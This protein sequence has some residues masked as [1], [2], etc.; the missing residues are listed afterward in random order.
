[1]GLFKSAPR[2]DAP[3]DLLKYFYTISALAAD[4]F[5]NWHRTALHTKD[6]SN[7]D[8]YLH[9]LRESSTFWLEASDNGMSNR[10]IM[11]IRMESGPRGN[12]STRESAMEMM[13]CILSPRGFGFA[14][15]VF[16]V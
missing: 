3:G 4:N 7:V 10:M 12:L 11:S 13:R 9:G 1:M 6:F 16:L 2:P 8:T 15:A 14:I 5:M